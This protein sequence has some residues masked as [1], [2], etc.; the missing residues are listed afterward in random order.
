MSPT[1][2]FYTGLIGSLILVA[3]A[4]WPDKEKRPLKSKKN[5]L[6]A[7]G[8]IVLLVYSYFNYLNDGPIF[9]VFLE[10]LAVIASIMMM[11]DFE[12]KID[13]VVIGLITTAFIIWSL[14]L[15]EDY[16]T[17]F[18]ILG[19]SGISLGYTAQIGSQKRNISLFSGSVLIAIFSYIGASWIF[20]WL[21]VFFALFSLYY[22]VIHKW[23]S[24]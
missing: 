14:Y 18:F 19:L 23:S 5:W 10:G 15:F 17:I 3:G 21:N 22:I 20:F 6:L 12:D 2:V 13:N 7:I 9:F 16:N 4:A 11:L 8:A 1:L 24:K